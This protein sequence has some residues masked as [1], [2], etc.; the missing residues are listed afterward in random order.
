[1][2]RPPSD[3]CGSAHMIPCFT[4]RWTGLR[5]LQS[6]SP[7]ARGRTPP[8]PAL[9]ALPAPPALTA[10]ADAVVTVP[11]PASDKAALTI[12]TEIAESRWACQ[13]LRI[14][15]SSS[16]PRTI[17]RIPPGAREQT[18]RIKLARAADQAGAG[19]GSSWRG[20]VVVQCGQELDERGGDLGRTA[21]GQ[22]MADLAQELDPG[23]GQGRRQLM[24]RPDRDERVA[25][26]GEQQYRLPDT[27]QRGG[28]AGQLAD[29]RTLLGEEGTPHRPL[30]G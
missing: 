15:T 10:L 6:S 19:R 11:A 29:Q 3:P 2:K 20:P 8:L 13:S 23:I 1:M 5:P 27:R 16:T 21:A 17:S 28:Q 14:A 22:V 26:V 30:L 9:A 12:R 25:G 4:G 24:R 7:T 18:C